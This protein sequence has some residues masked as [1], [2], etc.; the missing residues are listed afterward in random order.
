MLCDTHV[1]NN[2]APIRFMDLG[3]IS[4]LLRDLIDVL[5]ERW[6]AKCCYLPVNTNNLEG[7]VFNRSD[8]IY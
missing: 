4:D 2:V 8:F 5:I 1:S 3:T 6:V 7:A